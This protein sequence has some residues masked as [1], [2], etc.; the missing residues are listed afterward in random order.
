M[1]GRLLEVSSTTAAACALAR[2][3]VQSG[4]E[5]SAW[6]TRG[7]DGRRRLYGPSL[8]RLAKMTVADDES[9]ARFRKWEQHPGFGGDDADASAPAPLVEVG[10]SVA[11]PAG[12]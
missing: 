11:V 1:L 7:Q 4:C 3:L 10:R 9:G 5:D 8:H 12:P 2:L 6:E